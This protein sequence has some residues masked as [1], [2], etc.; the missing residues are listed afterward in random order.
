MHYWQPGLHYPM[1]KTK[2]L[3]LS[4]LCGTMPAADAKTDTCVAV[5]LHSVAPDG[6][7]RAWG[8]TNKFWPNKSTLRVKFL[9]GSA[10]QKAKA[11]TYVQ[12]LDAL[13][14][15]KFVRVET[16]NSEIRVRF[17]SGSGHWSY[18]G[19]DNLS[20]PQSR[21]TMN[22]ELRS[23]VFGD[24]D[25][26][27]RRVVPHEFGHAVGLEHEHQHPNINIPWNV[28][29]VLA[30]YRAS[31]GWSDAE[32]HFQVLDHKSV[33]NW[34]G[35]KPDLRS[36]MMY[37]IPARHVTDTSYVVGW[38]IG[39]STLDVSFLKQKYPQ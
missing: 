16:G 4:L 37:P 24:N 2:L 33:S 29:V 22:L 28:P 21:Q 17:D 10:A 13:T 23:G 19:R 32:I 6:S 25:Q 30:D 26:E 35:T 15:L 27:W 8:Q 20:I 7:F 18:L 31:Q 9:S 38:N 1:M 14:G 39:Y 12:E 5:R 34:T 3:I 36:S 11:W